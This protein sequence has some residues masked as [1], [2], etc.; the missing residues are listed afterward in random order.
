M[1]TNWLRWLGL[2]HV[3]LS[4]AR[5]ISANVAPRLW[6]GLR[7]AGVGNLQ[8]LL[9]LAVLVHLVD[10]VRAADELLVHVELRN[11]GPVAVLLDGLPISCQ[12]SLH[13]RGSI[14]SIASTFFGGVCGGAWGR[15]DSHR[16]SGSL[17]TSK[18]SNCVPLACST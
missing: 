15:G 14:F 17:R 6:G 7:L 4:A 8:H 12:F 2:A 5:T 18:V 1:K 9:K 16:I 13:T 11:G 10:D 3:C